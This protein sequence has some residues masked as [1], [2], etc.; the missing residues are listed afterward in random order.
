MG[1]R[2]ESECGYRQNVSG[3]HRVYFDFDCTAIAESQ[4]NFRGLEFGG[5][6][7]KDDAAN[8]VG[9]VERI[10]F[11][12]LNTCGRVEERG[13]V[14]LAKRVDDCKGVDLLQFVGG[15]FGD[16]DFAGLCRVSPLSSAVV[17]RRDLRRRDGETVATDCQNSVLL[18]PVGN[19]RVVGSDRLCIPNIGGSSIQQCFGRLLGGNYVATHHNESQQKK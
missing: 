12:F 5:V 11:D 6:K 19:N 1:F 14:S 4:I 7:R 2:I 16:V 17:P 3:G 15:R 13:F 18:V 10:E 9:R 8:V